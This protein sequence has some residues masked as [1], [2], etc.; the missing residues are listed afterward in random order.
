MFVRFVTPIIHPQS[1]V[2]SGL[3]RAFDLYEDQ[4]LIPACY[5]DRADELFEWFNDNLPVPDRLSRVVG[6]FRIAFGVCWLKPSAVDHICYMWD[7]AAIY[8]ASGIPV[9]LLKSSRPGYLLYEDE[10]QIV[11]QPT[12]SLAR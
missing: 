8:E 1:R 12:T 4:D 11:A 10:F 7:L 5:L 3:F 2:S 6:R 9:Q